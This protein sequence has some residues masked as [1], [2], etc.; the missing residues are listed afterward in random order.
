MQRYDQQGL[1][2]FYFLFF[3]EIYIYSSYNSKKEKLDT[4]EGAEKKEPS[5]IA[6]N[7]D[8]Y[9]SLWKTV[10]KFLKKVKIE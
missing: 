9:K 2:F 8:W 3:F 7:V 1:N 6:G 10:W 4:K 5:Y